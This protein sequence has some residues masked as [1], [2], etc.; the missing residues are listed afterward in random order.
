M[1][2]QLVYNKI[3]DKLVQDEN[4]KINRNE[5]IIYYKSPVSVILLG[6]HTHYNDG[7]IIS[8]ALNRYTTVKVS[9]R[10]DLQI[11]VKTKWD[12]AEF[13]CP[14]GTS[15]INDYKYP[16]QNLASVINLLLQNEYQVK[17]F[18]CEIES[19][20]PE[21]MGN[22]IYAA[23]QIPLLK[24]VNDLFELNIPDETIIE[25]SRKAEL[26]L[27]GKISNIAHHFTSMYSKINHVTKLDLRT[28]EIEFLKFDSD[29]QPVIIE[30]GRRINVKEIC[31]ERIEE[32]EVGV[33]GL[34]L[35]I[36]GIK[37]L[38]DIKQDFLQKH[39]HM[40]PNRVY[41]RC[42]FNVT[43][44]DRVTEAIEALKNNNIHLFGKIMFES[45]NALRDEYEISCDELDFVV[46]E[47]SNIGDVI[48]SKILSCTPISSTINIIKKGSA[49]KNIDLIKRVYYNK[50]GKELNLIELESSN[51]VQRS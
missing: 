48:G 27:I 17:G 42:L 29:V 20:I 11:L 38:R 32:C 43:E 16:V 19:D 39:I 24:S 49:V 35:Y 4:E 40:I 44:R 6:D 14:L 26:N 1:Q 3:K 8:S 36:W 37:N 9:K 41:R 23:F 10:D 18:N 7:I 21:C 31:K 5:N 22:G 47:S 15:E 45:H 50:F 12:N 2:D 28:K 30:T 33:K 34:R 25:I 13:Y 46:K 51:G